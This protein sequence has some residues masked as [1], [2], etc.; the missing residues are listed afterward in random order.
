MAIAPASS[1]TLTTSNSMTSVLKPPAERDRVGRVHEHPPAM[2]RRGVPSPQFRHALVLLGADLLEP[3]LHGVA[4]VRM[5]RVRDHELHGQPPRGGARAWIAAGW[6]TQPYPHL[7]RA[8]AIVHPAL[9]V[10]L[11]VL[12]V[13]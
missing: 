4:I 12:L 10:S 13:P 2:S 11:T 8:C 1:F 3:L 9:A 5:E 6:D 7:N